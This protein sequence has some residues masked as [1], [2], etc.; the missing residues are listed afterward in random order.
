MSFPSVVFG[1]IHGV[2]TERYFII[3]WKNAIGSVLLML[4]TVMEFIES[5]KINA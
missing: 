3:K 1:N 5:Y 2:T 4:K